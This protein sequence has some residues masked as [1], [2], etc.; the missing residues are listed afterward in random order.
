MLLKSQL[1][2]KTVGTD[3]QEIC[4]NS[5][6]TDIFYKILGTNGASVSA[7][8]N[9]DGLPPGMTPGANTAVTATKQKE[10]VTI[11]GATATSSF[12]LIINGITKT[13]GVGGGDA[14]VAAEL[15]AAIIADATLS[16]LVATDDSA[17]DGNVHR[18][19]RV[20]EQ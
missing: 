8:V 17:A 12:S 9:F 19:Y 1:I 18:F 4:N 11:A 3:D 6:I 2:L 5:P 16:A 13:S 14:A 10:K 7:L 15:E 20:M